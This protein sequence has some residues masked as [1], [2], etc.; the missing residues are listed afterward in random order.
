M[1]PSFLEQASL[2][3]ELRHSF[4]RAVHYVTGRQPT[5]E[6]VE[7]L[8]RAE[9]A[10]LNQ[11]LG[12]GHCRQLAS[13][14][15]SPINAIGAPEMEKLSTAWLT[16]EQLREVESALWFARTHNIASIPDALKWYVDH[17]HGALDAPT[18]PKCVLDF[19]AVKRT[20]GLRPQ[21]L[22]GLRIILGKFADRFGDRQPMAITP[23]VMLDYLVTAKSASTREAWW[24]ALSTFFHW[25]VRMRY[26]FDNPVKLAQKQPKH[27]PPGR[28]ILT[29]NETRELLRRAKFTS[30]IGFWVFSLFAGL[31]SIELQRLNEHADPWSLIN[32]K[33][34][35]IEITRNIAKGRPRLVPIHPVL[36]Q[37]IRWI[38][39]RHAPFYPP[40]HKDRSRWIRAVMSDR[41]H[42]LQP[43]KHATSQRD[44]RFYNI[45]R[46]SYVSYRLALPHASFAQ[47]AQESGHNEAVLRKFYFRRATPGEACE[48]FALTPK[49]L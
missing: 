2:D 6:E 48:Y 10:N 36:R 31:R 3:A 39:F 12:E 21:S 34:G 11:D 13:I 25:A 37:W 18:L 44:E 30:E 35:F 14:G 19:L 4:R 24:V 43:E 9:I 49:F 32:L 29:P 16:P 20:E 42:Q 47:V 26:A 33:T 45:P 17:R 5:E 22:R 15:V 8:V 7:A 23:R 27:E 38:R 28:L 41:V 46:R 1:A 40:N